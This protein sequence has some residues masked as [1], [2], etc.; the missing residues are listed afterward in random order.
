M[1]QRIALSLLFSI[2][3]LVPSACAMETAKV[4]SVVDGDTVNIDRGKGKE[5][6]ILYGIDCPELD[7]AAG[8]EA[9]AFTNERCWRKSVSV[10]QRGV[11]S[12]GRVIAVVLLPDGTNLSEE[13]VRRG[14]AWWSD[15]YAPKDAALKKLHSGAQAAKIGLWAGAN[16][17]P[18][19]VWRNGQKSVQAT[20]V[21]GK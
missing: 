2:A 8:A 11:D 16:P 3:L 18:P 15:K 4:V 19:W 20:I 9:R 10:D 14:L 17:V 13:L 7:Q 5:R 6:V 1:G 12:K 21:P